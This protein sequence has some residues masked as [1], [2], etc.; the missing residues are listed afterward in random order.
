MTKVAAGNYWPGLV[1][2]QFTRALEHATG[3]SVEFMEYL[4]LAAGY[5]LAG[6]TLEDVFFYVYGPARSGKGTITEPLLAALGDYGQT[7]KIETF[8]AR[9]RSGHAS[10]SDIARMA[11]A[12]MVL[13]A[14]PMQGEKLATGFIKDLTGGFKQVARFLFRDEF[15]FIPQLTLWLTANDRLYVDHRDAPLY[16]RLIVCPFDHSLSEEQLDPG[17]KHQLTSDQAA[18]DAILTWAVEGCRRWWQLSDGGHRK[19]LTLRMPAAVKAATEAYRQSQNPL[20]EFIE[21]YCALDSEGW[22]AGSDLLDAVNRSLPITKSMTA[23]TLGKH[24]AALPGV[25]AEQER[26]GARR[27]GWRGIGLLPTDAEGVVAPGLTWQRTA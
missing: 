15:E 23:K 3:G 16:R 8:L 18:L 26:G 9:N 14:E 5:T 25:T 27:R 20:S 1:L 10:S 11:G 13:T 19:V 4:Q 24:L 12:R 6:A 21:D 17:L 22:T 7:A 2:Q